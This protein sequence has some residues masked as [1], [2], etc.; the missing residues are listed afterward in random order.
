[1]SFMAENPYEP[2]REQNHSPSKKARDAAPVGCSVILAF[3]FGSTFAWAVTGVVYMQA[4]GGV[5][6][7]P[8]GSF[9]GAVC[10]FCPLVGLLAA[11]IT[12]RVLRP[13]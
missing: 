10:L 3:V 8:D 4:I 1:M 12:S 13:R 5:E 7:H 6:L 2:P 9:M 11:L